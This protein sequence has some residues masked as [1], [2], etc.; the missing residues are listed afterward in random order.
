MSV[1]VD[2]VITWFEPRKVY[3]LDPKVKSHIESLTKYYN[4]R[5]ATATSTWTRLYTDCL[6]D[7][8][9]ELIDTTD[10]T[11]QIYKKN[12]GYNPYQLK[13]TSDE[14]RNKT[15]KRDEE[16]N[17]MTKKEF[18][19]LFAQTINEIITEKED[20]Y[21]KKTEA[22]NVEYR[23]NYRQRVD[24]FCQK[25][26]G[27]CEVDKNGNIEPKIDITGGKSKKKSRKRNASKRRNRRTR[28]YK[29]K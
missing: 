8:G 5:V 19:K 4:S 11:H 15:R 22:E 14:F 24:E 1:T 20:A 7:I 29:K 23:K 27:S 18:V 2:D 17:Q 25:N 3:L 6:T 16:L 21:E 12:Q 26:P 28:N 10:V 9:Y 13:I